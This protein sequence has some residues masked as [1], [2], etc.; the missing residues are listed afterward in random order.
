M[1][2]HACTSNEIH[3]RNV[4]GPRTPHQNS[5]R[6]LGIIHAKQSLHTFPMYLPRQHSSYNYLGRCK[7]TTNLNDARRR[8]FH[9][10]EAPLYHDKDNLVGFAFVD[11]TIIVEGYLTNT[12]ITIEDVHI[13]MKK[14]IDIWEG[15]LKYTGGSIRPDKSFI[16]PISFT[17]YD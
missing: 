10:F 16:Y 7:C 12:E 13:R 11:D 15:G 2:S 1:T 3:S 17:W 9:K 8:T 4:A 6:K 14:N 5:L